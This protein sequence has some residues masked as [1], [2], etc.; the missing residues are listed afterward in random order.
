MAF[1]P[2]VSGRPLQALAKFA[3]TGAGA[4]LLYGVSRRDMGI[5]ALAK[6][7]ESLLGEL[8]MDT[9][10]VAGRA[11]REAPPANL[12][13]PPPPWSGTSATLT[14]AYRSHAKTPIEVV[15]SALIKARALAAQKPS[16]G[17]ILDERADR[18]RA[19]AAASTE[20][21]RNGSARGLFDGVPILV[22]EQTAVEGLPRRAGSDLTDADPAVRDAT[23]VARLRAAGAIVLG[24]T[25][26]TEFGMTPLGYNP[27]RNMPR[28]PHASGHLA[29]GSST[30]SGV[31]VATGVVPFAVGGDGGGS[32]RIPSSLCGVFGIKPTWGRVSVAGDF[33]GGTV[34]HL[35]PLASST[36]DLARFLEITSGFDPLDTQTALA[37]PRVEGS[38]AAAIGRGVKGL[39][40]GVVASEWTEAED[41]VATAGRAALQALVKEGAVLV[42]M[43]LELARYAAAIGYLTITLEGLGSQLDMYES[44]APFN[45]DL[46]ITYAA[47]TKAPATEYVRAQRMRSAL[48]QELARAFRDIDVLALPTT[49]TTAPAVT[50]AQFE[51]G[52]LD[53]LATD[54]MCR[55]NFLGNLTGLPALS[56]PVGTDAHDL[57]IGL[58]I[59]GDAWDEATTL[60]VGAHLERMGVATPKKP[61]AADEGA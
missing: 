57:P 12:A 32:I 2:R 21:W 28:N 15:E 54:A 17:P 29:G 39:R 52:F 18:A 45:P 16:C 31:A 1:P 19:E 38:F 41:A 59:V 43:K 14:A 50:D 6:V 51:G 35:G 49:A 48:R 11:P 36:L 10:P 9:R 40:I 3:R 33:F 61:R 60:A 26:M 7:P 30:G 42:D 55:F 25:M 5:G 4:S 44:A 37:P 53:A 22:K 23:C 46:M 56:A 58:Q 20:R 8:A 47:V 34:A 24:T 27:K 13:V